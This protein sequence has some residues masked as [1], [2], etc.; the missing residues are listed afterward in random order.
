MFVSVPSMLGVK[1]CAFE[2]ALVK[3]LI[4]SSE[5]GKGKGMLRLAEGNMTIP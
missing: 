3:F 4:Q 5:Q 2:A 1:F